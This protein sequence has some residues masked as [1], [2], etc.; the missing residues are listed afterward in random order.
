MTEKQPAMTVNRVQLCCRK[1]SSRI[2]N[3]KRAIWQ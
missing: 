2:M 3:Q 1:L